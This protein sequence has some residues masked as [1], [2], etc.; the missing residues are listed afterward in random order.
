MLK[1]FIDLVVGAVAALIT[2][3]V[4]AL[5]MV[6]SAVSFRARPWFVQQRIGRGGEPFRMVKIRSL[7]V[8]TD[9]AIDKYQLASVGTT[10]FGAFIRRTHLDELPQLWSVVAGTMSLVGPRPEMP[11]LDQRFGA[12]QRASR[13]RFRPGCVGL[14]QT[15][16]HNTGL[17]YEHPEYDI[18]YAANHSAALDVYIVWCTLLMECTGRR[19]RLADVPRRLL[20]H[21]CRP[22]SAPVAA[23]VAS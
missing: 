4:V 5:L 23:E 8:D 13:E 21:P 11:H 22:E 14:W 1:R 7:S 20:P 9:P 16:E 18:A 12:A 17:M 19:V 6:V 10:R 15:S 3:P 2:L